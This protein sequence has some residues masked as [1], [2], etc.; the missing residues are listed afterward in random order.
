MPKGDKYI[1]LIK[2][3]KGRTER[4]ISMSFSDIE[5]MVGES[6]PSSAYK[7]RE[8]W[9]NTRSHSVAYGWLDAGYKTIRVDLINHQIIFEKE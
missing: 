5:K 2:Y 8:F 6:L 3:L 4:T 1:G 7:Y 9:S